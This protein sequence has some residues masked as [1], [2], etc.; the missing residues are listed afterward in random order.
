MSNQTGGQQEKALARPPTEELL[1]QLERH[2]W[3]VLHDLA[4][5]PQLP[6]QH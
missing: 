6:G 4:S 3:A 2:G 1:D 5:H